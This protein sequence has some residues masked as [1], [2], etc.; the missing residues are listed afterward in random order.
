MGVL[1][2]NTRNVDDLARLRRG[3]LQAGVSDLTGLLTEDRTEQALLGVCSV[4]PF[5]VT[6]PT[7]DALA[8]LDLAPTR[9]MPRS[10]KSARISSE[11]FGMS[12]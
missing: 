7:K 4:S 6:L 8:R 12:R 5:G 3:G 10:S 11:R 1:T 2:E 9:I